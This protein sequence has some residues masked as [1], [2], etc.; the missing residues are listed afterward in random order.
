[1]AE[2]SRLSERRSALVEK[3]ALDGRVFVVME[4]VEGHTLS[5][6]S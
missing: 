3:F 5:A 4:F 2:A 6:C 1:M